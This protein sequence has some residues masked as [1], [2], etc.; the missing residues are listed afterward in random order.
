[1]VMVCVGLVSCGGS[2]GSST[3]SGN[4]P[5]STPPASLPGI[6]LGNITPIP[7]SAGAAKTSLVLSN[8]LSAALSL[9]ASQSNIVQNGKTIDINKTQ[10]VSLDTC[11]I[12]Q[13]NGSCSVGINIPS[14]GVGSFI[15][16]LVYTDQKTQK[17]Y[18]A[19]QL[20]TYANDIP[21]FNGFIYSNQNTNVYKP[22]LQNNTIS[23]P[24]VL[25]ANYSNVEVIAANRAFEV[26]NVNCPGFAKNTLCTA[27][28]RVGNIGDINQI[29]ANV[30]ISGTLV[31]GAKNK[32]VE[33]PPSNLV[34]IP[35]LVLQNNVANILSSAINPV[36]TPSDGTATPI[37][38]NLS[39]TGSVDVTNATIIGGG[40]LVIASNTCASISAGGS[41]SFTINQNN[42]QNGSAVVNVNSGSTILTAFNVSYYMVATPSMTVTSNINNLNNTLINTDAYMPMVVKNTGNVTLTNI[43]F[44]QASSL[45]TYMTY[46]S[47]S[48]CKTDGTGS[49]P[50]NGSCTLVIKYSPTAIQAQSSFR[51]VASASSGT[52]TVFSGFGFNYSAVT[53]PALLYFIPN[54][55]SFSINADGSS[56]QSQQFS[57]L[58][59][60]SI[61]AT[62]IV[63]VT[64]SGTMSTFFTYNLAG[65]TCIGKTTLNPNESCTINTQYGPTTVAESNAPYSGRLVESYTAVPGGPTTNAYAFI[66]YQSTLSGR[67]IVESF[68]VS[69]AINP[70]P[71]S[72]A[73][74]NSPTNRI[75][76]LI[77]YRNLGAAAA[78]SFNVNLAGIPLGYAESTT[79]LPGT[80]CGTGTTIS[81]LAAGDNCF[82]SVYAVAPTQFANP[83]NINGALNINIP[84]FSYTDGTGVVINSAPTYNFG[85]GSVNTVNVT[86]N[87]FANVSE[88]H[89]SPI[90]RGTTFASIFTV[91]TPNPSPITFNFPELGS[92]GIYYESATFCTVAANSPA[93]TTCQ[94]RLVVESNTPIQPAPGYN[95]KYNV[96]PSASATGPAMNN[97]TNI[98]LQ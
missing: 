25:D 62:N 20:V 18:T 23:I 63:P 84:G 93:N 22:V 24:F 70:S 71:G 57:L 16:N 43:Q 52:G 4:G 73:F 17:T 47:S 88:S 40:G 32:A 98:V 79:G 64:T 31:L 35:V 28:I 81:T 13:A 27:V 1:M 54:Y 76:M 92:S 95:I 97:S 72:Y 37:T 14:N 3:G 10:L 41:C 42:G 2:S 11:Q 90:T 83:Y 19:S 75:G 34:T 60:G 51:L 44:T 77:S 61:Q 33:K 89:P 21:A 6:F 80:K 39:N 59:V 74:T 30:T 56:F 46:D 68:I 49:L 91:I 45:P 29:V 85:S 48:L 36:I 7:T 55:V 58:N 94:I 65:S 26:T 12:V 5:G 53:N 78:T 66:Q 15:L 8:N 86:A 69:N 96:Y 38:I 67:V 50:A 9:V 87:L 82:V